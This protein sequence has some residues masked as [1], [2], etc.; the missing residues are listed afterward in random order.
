MSSPPPLEGLGRKADQGWGEGC[1]AAKASPTTPRIP[2][3]QTAST[4]KLSHR[5]PI[6]RLNAT[7]GSAKRYAYPAFSIATFPPPYPTTAAVQGNRVN[8][9]LAI[10]QTSLSL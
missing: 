10:E 6:R 8:L 4:P 1:E 2:N 7:C 3:H 9:G 5:L